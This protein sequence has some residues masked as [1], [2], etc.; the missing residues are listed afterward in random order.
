MDEVERAAARRGRRTAA[1]AICGEH[2]SGRS[3]DFDREEELARRADSGAQLFGA[4][5]GRRAALFMQIAQGDLDDARYCRAPAIHR[6]PDRNSRALSGLSH[7][8]AVSSTRRRRTLRFWRRPSR[9]RRSTCLPSDRWL[10]ETAWRMAR[11]SAH[12]SGADALQNDRARPIP[13]IERAAVRQGRG[14]YRLLSLRPAYF[15]QRRRFRSPPASAAPPPNSTAACRRAAAI[16]RTR[17]WRP[18]RTITNAARMC[19]LGSP[20]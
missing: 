3:G 13:A 15:A 17:C 4:A 9:A 1:D 2:V 10:V 19:A 7:L 14:G 18:R 8:R 5:R 12:R 16:F 20:C 6:V 11:R